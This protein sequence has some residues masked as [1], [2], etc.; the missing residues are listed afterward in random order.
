MGELDFI[1]CLHMKRSMKNGQ[2]YLHI[3]LLLGLHLFMVKLYYACKKPQLDKRAFTV[4]GSACCTSPLQMDED[5]KDGFKEKREKSSGEDQNKL[6]YCVTDAPPWYLC[7]V[8]SIQVCGHLL[9][10]HLVILLVVDSVSVTLIWPLSFISDPQI[11]FKNKAAI[12][13]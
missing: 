11:K 3:P 12:Y 2:T 8:L 4:C 6:T 9:C 13:F 7:I 5:I 1:L 10:R